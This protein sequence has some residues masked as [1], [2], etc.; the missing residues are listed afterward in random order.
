MGL[1][2]PKVQL[3]EISWMASVNEWLTTPPKKYAC[4]TISNQSESEIIKA[5]YL[6]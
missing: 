6:K 2:L 5:N 4:R 3:C 1:L